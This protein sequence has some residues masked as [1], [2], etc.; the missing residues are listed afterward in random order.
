MATLNT[1]I[2]KKIDIIARENNSTLINIDITDK[3][4]GAFDLSNYQVD[5]Y[6]YNDDDGNLLYFTNSNAAFLQGN[7]DG[8]LGITTTEG[9]LALDET[10][11]LVINMSAANL[12]K[13]NPGSYKHRL[14]LKKGTGQGLLAQITEKTWMYGKFKL[15]KD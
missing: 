3:D 15:N 9:Q 12:S 4:G 13:L 14:V 2:A 8:A 1:D 11:K 7:T 5:F 6:I 10:G